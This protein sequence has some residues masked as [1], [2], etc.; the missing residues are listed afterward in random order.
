MDTGETSSG[1]VLVV[2]GEPSGDR[3][4]A[5]VVEA[6]GL[7]R[8]SGVFGIG[9]DHLAAAG[10]HLVT[11]IGDLTALGIA[12]SVGRFGAW[13]SAWARIR[14]QIDRRRPAA[15]LLVDAPDVNLPLARVLSQKKI[16]VVQYVG[17][18]VW[19]WRR[20]RLRLLRERTD[21]VA[22][23]LP[24][25]EDIYRRAGVKATY[26]GHPALDEK[27][28]APRSVVR[29]RLHLAKGTPLVA[30]LP[31]SRTSEVEAL[32]GPMTEA[33]L[34]LLREGI[35]SVFA[36]APRAASAQTMTAARS[37]GC[38]VLPRDVSV[39][40]LLGACDAAIVASGTVTIEAAL[41][42][43][44]MA[45]VYKIDRVSWVVAQ[46]AMDI[47]CIGLPNWIAGRAIV[48]ELLQD[49]VTGQS[50]FD[51]ARSLLQPDVAKSQRAELKK[52]ID[53]L[54]SPGVGKRVAAILEGFLSN[55]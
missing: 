40:D 34:R 31:G 41:E 22:L 55:R 28:S 52:V 24:F 2:A 32:C 43:A 37:A 44:P 48:P 14:E 35:C 9:G 19:A 36:P 6:L 39:R 26:V 3:A 18:Q 13:C 21:H 10:V 38:V 5:R 30:L 1:G 45:I 12:E 17:P 11:H 20:G 53:A 4:A 46:F 23:V 50:I 51:A 54:G 33:G 49:R 29:K 8:Q 15:A 42:G 47:P 25:E 16:P 7:S 27:P